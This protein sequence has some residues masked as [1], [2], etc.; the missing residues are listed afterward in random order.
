MLHML[1]KYLNLSLL[2]ALADGIT[3]LHT[4]LMAGLTESLLS[5]G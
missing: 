4:H 5:S 1:R 2:S 3:D